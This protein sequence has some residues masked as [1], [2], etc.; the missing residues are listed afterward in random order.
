[1]SERKFHTDPG[2]G[3]W[4]LVWA[5]A[6]FLLAGYYFYFGFIR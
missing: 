1:M 6:S 5:V 4:L 3:M 2:S